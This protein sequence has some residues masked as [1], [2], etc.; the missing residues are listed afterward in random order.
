MSA[1][2]SV[3]SSPLTVEPMR[4]RHLS[5]VRA[6]DA[7][8]YPQPW[9]LALYLQELNR[10]DSRVYSVVRDVRSIVGYAGIMIVV[11]D[12]HVTSVATD[13]VAVGRGIATRA[14]LSVAR[15][16]VAKG[17]TALTLEVRVSNERAQ[18][19]YRRFG[20]DEAGIRKNY[21]S[22]VGEDA[23]IMWANDVDEVGYLARL[24]E[25]EATLSRPTEWVGS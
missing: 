8:V 5:A 14:L 11:G 6:I 19:L 22:D 23:M 7:K 17:C 3:P 10:P 12:G 13:P 24:R 20:F 9:S 15:G 25:I 1:A 18:S 2:A 16:A 21:Y 4:R